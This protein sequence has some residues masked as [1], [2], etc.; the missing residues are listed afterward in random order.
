[1]A[2]ATTQPTLLRAT[3]SSTF[4]TVANAYKSHLPTWRPLEER[5][6]ALAAECL[7]L[8]AEYE[9]KKYNQESLKSRLIQ[10]IVPKFFALNREVEKELSFPVDCAKYITRVLKTCESPFSIHWFERELYKTTLVEQLDLS[11]ELLKRAEATLKT[12]IQTPWN[13]AKDALE[14]EL[15]LAGV[16]VSWGSAVW[17]YLPERIG[18]TWPLV[19]HAL[20]EY[21]KQHPDEIRVLVPS[22]GIVP[23]R[24]TEQSDRPAFGEAKAA[25]EQ[26]KKETCDLLIA[27]V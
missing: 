13:I 20:D 23:V 15:S 21:A 4:Q 6:R 10:V 2:A 14:K 3:H 24:P 11:F 25:L 16:S 17:G 7:T 27:D 22:S 19:N 18:G 12:R 5:V 8:K 26:V 1:M 9:N